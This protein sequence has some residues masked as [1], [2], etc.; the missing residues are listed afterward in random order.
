MRA[1]RCPKP[2]LTIIIWHIT[3]HEIIRLI[4][5]EEETRDFRAS[6]TSSQI[7]L[8]MCGH[9]QIY[10]HIVQDKFPEAIIHRKIERKFYF[11][12]LL[13]RI[14]PRIKIL[15]RVIADIINRYHQ[16]FNS[17]ITITYISADIFKYYILKFNCEFPDF[18]LKNN[19]EGEW[20]LMYRDINSR[21]FFWGRIINI[22]VNQMKSNKP[23]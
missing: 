1:P 15:H 13:F 11:W 22:R 10:V 21:A 6:L 16:F 3:R 2:R 7:T 5:C 12:F 23:E 17:L 19:F 18:D 8:A 9:V 14:L 4:A 20:S